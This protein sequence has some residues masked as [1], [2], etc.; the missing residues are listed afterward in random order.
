M[1][2]K[3][4]QFVAEVLVEKF[5]RAEEYFVWLN[6]GVRAIVLNG[7]HP[8]KAFDFARGIIGTDADSWQKDIVYLAEHLGQR[9]PSFH[10][11][12]AECLRNIEP[13]PMSND[14]STND[15]RN[16]ESL[17][18]ALLSLARQLKVSSALQ[19]IEGLIH[20]K[21]PNSQAVYDAAL[22]TWRI[23]ANY[24]SDT[25]W[26]EV[27]HRA[28]HAE[29]RYRNQYSS[30]L[31][32]GMCVARPGLTAKY[33]RNWSPLQH[34]LESLEADLSNVSQTTSKKLIES[35]AS[36]LADH[37]ALRGASFTATDISIARQMG[38]PLQLEKGLLDAAHK[39]SRCRW[40][41]PSKKAASVST[42]AFELT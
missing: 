32:F 12:I 37:G 31:A 7:T 23:M 5:S 10:F 3:N 21:L 4:L 42:G 26:I 29:L 16:L 17:V 34:Y 27:F 8:A 38:Q 2:E 9:L 25:D 13:N 36:V 41:L 14:P 20:T 30:I 40:Q 28:R 39:A 18:I 24:D 11:A 35:I 33:L 19:R 15:G 6:T 22:L 1:Q